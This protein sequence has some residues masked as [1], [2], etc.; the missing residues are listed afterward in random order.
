[1]CSVTCSPSTCR[2]QHIWQLSP[3]LGRRYH[4]LSSFLF[5]FRD[6]LNDFPNECCRKRPALPCSDTPFIQ[7]D[8]NSWSPPHTQYKLLLNLRQ[9]N[10]YHIIIIHTKFHQLVSLWHQSLSTMTFCSNLLKDSSR[11]AWSLTGRTT[12]SAL[13][14]RKTSRRAHHVAARSEAPA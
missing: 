4:T 13:S 3:T 10:F 6:Q 2:T 7:P 11:P 14:A 5:F 9:R 8:I 1:M 12:S